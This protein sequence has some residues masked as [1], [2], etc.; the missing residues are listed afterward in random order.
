MFRIANLNEW[1]AI[2]L[3]GNKR[4]EWTTITLARVSLGLFFAIS[5]FNKLFVAA[6]QAAL[7]KVMI[8]AG[9]PFPEITAVFLATV[10]FVGGSFLII[11]FLSTFC[12]IA[13]TIAMLVA[14]VTVELHTI[15]AGLSFLNWLDYFLYLPQVMYV[16][17][18]LWLMVSGPGPV[19]LDSY[20]ARAIER[21]SGSAP[22]AARRGLAG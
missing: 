2:V 19:S 15:P 13:L 4:W 8:E 7:V 12:A 10:E 22:H 20:L 11:G 14:I 18:F 9:I 3:Q 5:G 6:N 21:A 16:V 1:I 17:I